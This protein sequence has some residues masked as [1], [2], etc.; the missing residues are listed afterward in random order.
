[1]LELCVR[2]E[3][4]LMPKAASSKLNRL[5]NRLT[6]WLRAN[7]RRGSRRNIT[8]HYDLGNDF[9]LPWLDGGMN[10][11]S[12]LFA[13]G[14]TLEA[15]Q[16]AKLDR[17]AALLEL[18]G[19][20]DVLEIGC[21]WGALAER[22][23]H[24]FAVSIYAVTLSSE[25]LSYTR[26]RLSSDVGDGRADVR[27][28]DYRDVEGQFDRI[29]SIEM[30]EAV[31]ESYWPAYF[32]KLRAS[33][34]QGGLVVLQSIIIAEDRFAA[35]RKRPD[36]IQR[37]IFPGGMLPTRGIIEREASRA[38]LRLVHHELFG[39]SYAKTLYEWRARF[40]RAWPKIEKLG[41]NDRFRRMWDYYLAYCE[42]GFR[43]GIVDVGFFKL[44]DA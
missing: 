33:L 31:G 29:A 22:L 23:L 15:A 4:A 40:L 37:H 25:Q 7:T 28:L 18:D 35:Y 39:D 32:A 2:N 5:R 11:S 43:T 9:F 14:D 26:R 36:F 20:E 41:F 24:R 34:R 13:G 38:G 42:V 21:G 16:E 6:H 3:A 44:A 27:L 17:I 19:G 30:I 8:A 1:L 12:A 10:Y